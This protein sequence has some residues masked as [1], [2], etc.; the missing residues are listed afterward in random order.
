MIV[1]VLVDALLFAFLQACSQ[2]N[3]D[4]VFFFH[5]S[6]FSLLG[7][8]LPGMLRC[9]TFQSHLGPKG[10]SC[11]QMYD[12]VGENPKICR[13]AF[14][15]IK[16]YL[17]QMLMASKGVAYSIFTCRVC[18]SSHNQLKFLNVSGVV[19]GLWLAV[20]L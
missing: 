15:R 16:T 17:I 4:F 13:A 19:D 5:L 11:H 8:R 9:C 3:R 7:D 6:P 18:F 10:A 12:K 14:Q 2:E 20:S 1:G